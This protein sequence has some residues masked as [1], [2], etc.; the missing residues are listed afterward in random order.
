MH[1]RDQLEDVLWVG[2]LGCRHPAGSSVL[3]RTAT[4]ATS[5][6]L[7]VTTE[8]RPES[9]V[10]RTGAVVRHCFSVFKLSCSAGP[11]SSG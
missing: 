11:H 6:A 4:M 1:H 8:Q 2:L 5:L 7:V 3:M 10:R 9:K